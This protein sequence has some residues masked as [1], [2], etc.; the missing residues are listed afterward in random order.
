M[1]LLCFVD[2][3]HVLVRDRRQLNGF[4]YVDVQST[5][6]DAQLDF[7]YFFGC[8]IDALVEDGVGCSDD[9]LGSGDELDGGA[10]DG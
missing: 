7:I 2:V 3:R 6:L 8:F 1:I 4:L 9:I 5:C 10:V